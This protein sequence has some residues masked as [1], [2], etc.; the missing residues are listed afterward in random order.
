MGEVMTKGEFGTEFQRLRIAGYRLPVFDGITIK[1]VI[2]EWYSTFASC[3]VE[4]FSAAIDKLKQTKTDTWWP[5]TGEIWAL[6][7]EVRHAR[8]IRSQ[9]DSSMTEWP[10]IP[11]DVREQLAAKFRD[12]AASLGR[13]M[14]MPDA[15]PQ[16]KPEESA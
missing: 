3:S 12:F 7:F 15:E 9:H 11:V 14:A 8:A 16:V 1:D 13:R 5:A 4:D 6:V 10:E 2:D